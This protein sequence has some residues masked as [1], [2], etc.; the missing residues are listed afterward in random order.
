[1][2]WFM[3][4]EDSE[5]DSYS[6]D[7][8][9]L[10]SP[11][12]ALVSSIRRRRSAEARFFKPVC[13]ISAIDLTD[14][15]IL[16]SPKLDAELIL[17]RFKAY[18]GLVFHSRVEMGWKPLWHLSNDGIWNF[19][20]GGVPL[21]PDEFGA[22]RPPGTKAILFNR[23]E[24][25]IVSER[26][27]ALWQDRE[28]R[29]ALRDAM[30]GILANDDEGCRRFARQL[31]YADR[32][33]EPRHWPEEEEVTNALR[34]SNAQL[35]LFGNSPAGETT[36]T[37]VSES[38]GV[39]N[40][41]GSPQAPSL[42]ELE[43]VASPT[44]KLTSGHEIDVAANPTIDTSNESAAI[45]ELPEIQ[46]A[47]IEVILASLPDNAPRGLRFALTAYRAE[48]LKRGTR[49]ILGILTNQYAIVEV[50]Y[51]HSDASDWLPP[52]LGQAAFP[53]FFKYHQLFLEHFPF[54]FEREKIIARIQ[55]DESRAIGE[56]L[57]RPFRA[58]LDMAQAAQ[59][60]GVATGDVVQ[61]MQELKRGAEFLASLPNDVPIIDL[62]R[63]DRIVSALATPKQ[64]LIGTAVGFLERAYN[65]LGTS[66]SLGTA[67]YPALA[68]NLASILEM[69]KSLMHLS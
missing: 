48:L 23:F 66:I 6:K 65:L 47:Q 49:P 21:R 31:F 40:N 20:A 59:N 32:A 16:S 9:L 37:S 35:D 33:M 24:E 25:L 10:K 62:G 30:L 13:L 4:D 7:A 58:A 54:I 29:K 22:D 43:A 26:Y 44:A 1:M 17:S 51:H 39:Q 12:D 11:W 46:T 14:D 60:A 52:G 57:I 67:T 50:E 41:L 5:N 61:F 63:E 34:I 28:Q 68:Q 42:K 64:R 38:Y 55:V 53:G 15:G 36:M 18:V 45:E 19:F 27:R 8:Q 2:N 3:P 56:E 69:L